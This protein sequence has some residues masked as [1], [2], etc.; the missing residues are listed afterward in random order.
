MS[1]VDA[2]IPGVS[3]EQTPDRPT[4]A[5]MIGRPP[6]RLHPARPGPAVHPAD[7]SA[8]W[9][10]AMYPNVIAGPILIPPDG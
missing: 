5:P 4:S 1:R 8:A 3:T 9:L 2:F 10:P 7:A 6:H